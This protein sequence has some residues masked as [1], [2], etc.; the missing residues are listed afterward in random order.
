MRVIKVLSEQI[1]E[2]LEDSNKYID[3]A[4]TYKTQFPKLAETYIELAN[5]E[6]GHAERLHKQV[7]SLISE[8]QVEIPKFMQELWEEKHIELIT[9][10]AELKTKI[11][12][13]KKVVLFF[14]LF[15]MIW[16]CVGFFVILHP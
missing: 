15:P 10:T 11:E 2:E 1:C 9:K 12:L 3:S 13:Y 4:L 14:L 5:E 6:I 16:C 8:I 7:V